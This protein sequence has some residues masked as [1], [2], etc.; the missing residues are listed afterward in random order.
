[1]ILPKPRRSL[2]GILG[3]SALFR[4]VGFGYVIG[5][6]KKMTFLRQIAMLE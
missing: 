2:G 6:L 4:C 5:I 3:R 1:V